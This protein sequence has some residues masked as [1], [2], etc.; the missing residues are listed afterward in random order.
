MSCGTN[1]HL[2]AIPE[3]SVKFAAKNH[4]LKF[5]IQS[6]PAKTLK[7]YPFLQNGNK[8]HQLCTAQALVALLLSRSNFSRMECNARRFVFLKTNFGLA[9]AEN[10]PPKS[11]KK[12]QPLGPRL[13]SRHLRSC[14][15][16][17]PLSLRTQQEETTRPEVPSPS[18]TN[19]LGRSS[20]I[21][22][23]LHEEKSLLALSTLELRVRFQRIE[24]HALRQKLFASRRGSVGKPYRRV[25]TTEIRD[26]RQ[27]DLYYRRLGRQARQKSRKLPELG[28]RIP[29]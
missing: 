22:L 9:R 17:Y 5:I 7:R 24:L 26:S 8:Y 27:R 6:K 3:K 20:Y 28:Q 2:L 21:L 18:T 10:G 25:K 14:A 4:R 12:T 16:S 13:S 19:A 1:L 23:T 15:A 29:T 11:L